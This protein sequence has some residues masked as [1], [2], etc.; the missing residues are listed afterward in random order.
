MH[1]SLQRLCPEFSNLVHNESK[2]SHRGRGLP[3]CLPPHLS[4]RNGVGGSFM[5]FPQTGKHDVVLNDRIRL[6]KISVDW[7]GM[8]S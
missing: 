6:E 7:T 3:T 5:K 1:R 2:G 4:L 8:R